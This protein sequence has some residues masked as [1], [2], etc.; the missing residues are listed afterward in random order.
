MIQADLRTKLDSKLNSSPLLISLSIA[1]VYFA[2]SIGRMLTKKPWC[3]EAWLASPAYNLITTGQMGTSFGLLWP[4]GI[5]KYTFW[6]PPLYFLI[7]AGWYKVLGFGLFAMRSLSLVTG[8]ILLFSL[9]VIVKS[10]SRSRGVALLAVLFTTV[11]ICFNYA[12]VD[13]R[14]DMTQAAFG[15]AGIAAY[16]TFRECNLRCAMLISHSLVACS[17]LTHPNGILPFVG[18]IFLTCYFDFARL[19]PKNILIALIPYIL[20]AICW[21]IYIF[22]DISL[23]IAQFG[24]NISGRLY[25][26]T[27]FWVGLK[28]EIMNRYLA[29]YG[30]GKTS[31]ILYKLPLIIL[32]IYI[33]AVLSIACNY[34]LRRSKGNKT[35]LFLVAIYFSVMSIIIGNKAHSYLVNIIPLYTSALAIWIDWRWRDYFRSYLVTL[36]IV[37]CFM[38]LQIGSLIYFIY[39]NNYNYLYLPAARILEQHSRQNQLIVGSAELAFYIGFDRNLIDDPNRIFSEHLNP[40]LI[41]IEDRYRL[42]MNQCNETSIVPFCNIV[43][44]LDNNFVQ[45]YKDSAYTIY[46]N[47]YISIISE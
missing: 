22:N 31:S 39:K 40:D 47:K 10:L 38:F 44:L 36:S 34:N 15:F 33:T 30:F 16:L 24:E 23:F 5:D 43:Y 17:G 28:L 2:A 45:I 26:L 6:Q 35:L 4:P 7:Q 25:G 46:S 20:G 21:G 42:A 1:L 37:A 12:A 27:S 13:G 11:D 8:I 29:T 9:Y 32:V 3:D 41:V 18:L 14:M 19:T